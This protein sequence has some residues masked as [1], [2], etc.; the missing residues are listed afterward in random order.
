MADYYPLISRAVSGLE[1]N[2]G[3]NRRALYERAR[4][5]LVDQLRAVQPALSETDITRE[6]LALEE[7]IRKVETDA[8]RHTRQPAP[9]AAP[10]VSPPP[11]KAPPPEPEPTAGGGEAAGGDHVSG[12]NADRA[13][14]SPSPSSPPSPDEPLLPPMSA[15]TPRTERKWLEKREAEPQPKPEPPREGIKGFSDVVAEAENLGAA[16]AQ[17]G[18]SARETYSAVPSPTP[19]FERLEPRLGDDDHNHN[20]HNHKVPEPPAPEQRPEPRLSEPRAHPPQRSGRI[21]RPASERP[22]SDRSAAAERSASFSSTSDRQRSS[23]RRSTGV[24]ADL[25][26]VIEPRDHEDDR[27]RSG[28]RSLEPQ[29]VPDNVRQAAERGQRE[30]DEDDDGERRPLFGRLTKGVISV[31]IALVLLLAIGGGIYWQR[32]KISSTFAGLFSRTQTTTTQRDTTLPRSTKIPDRVGQDTSQNNANQQAE[33]V[34]A[35]RAVLY[36]DDPNGAGK[37]YSGTVLWR[38]EK[39]V[40]GPGQPQDLTARADISIP[41]RN[42][43]VT[44]SLR[45]NNDKDLPAS[46]T[47]S[48][49]FTLPPDF[50]HGGIAEIRGVLMKQAE[51]TRGAT[52][53]GIAVKVTNNF[54]LIGLSST[55]ADV[56]RNIPLLKDR[57]WFDIAIVYTDGRRAILAVEKGPPG[58]RAF[59]DAFAAWGQ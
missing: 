30:Y 38:S 29:F 41:E 54:F 3:E 12:D 49:Q 40:P 19:E 21:E 6:R 45:R 59:A 9:S 2:S 32:N 37:S 11:P 58:D 44:W 5:A 43:Q 56:Q 48:I 51:Q 26:P 33:A 7:S 53:S 27:H 55:E 57:G 10:P 17:A 16:A 13:P 24:R 1:K 18:R 47:I 15:D 22:M 35:Q 31:G 52:L 4:K 25:G 36:E 20:L 8:V 50:P 23:E 28:A 46:H 14:S 34:V 42:M 39:I